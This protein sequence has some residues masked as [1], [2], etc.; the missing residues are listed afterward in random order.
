MSIALRFNGEQFYTDLRDRLV[1]TMDEVNAEFFRSATSGMSSDAKAASEMDHAVVEKETD[2]TGELGHNGLDEDYINARCHF[3]ADAILESF[4]VGSLS[5][6]GP[7]SQWEEYSKS[8]YFNKLRQG[9]RNIVGREAGPYTDIW[10][11]PQVS[12]G[13]KAGQNLESKSGKP[14]KWYDKNGVLHELAPQHPKYMIQNAEAWI[15]VNRET[16][17][18]RAIQTEIDRFIS[19]MSQDPLKYFYYVE[20]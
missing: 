8:P 5:D 13:G 7:Y 17:M 19:E 2:F 18:E 12:E 15:M 10:G 16:R 14:R 3:Y 11:N 6:N 20:V 4:G 1:A 9:T